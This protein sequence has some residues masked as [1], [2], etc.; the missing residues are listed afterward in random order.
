MRNE[1]II[2]LLLAVVL[3]VT[4]N[5]ML[6]KSEGFRRPWLGIFSIVAVL[7]AFGSLSRAIEGIDLGI[8]YA[9]WGAMGLFMTVAAGWIFFQ[10]RLNLRGWVGLGFLLS[11]IML[12]KLV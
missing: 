1:H 4:A 2:F 12:L 9:L 11:G 8:A 3:E 6:K 10:Q 5:I 7:S